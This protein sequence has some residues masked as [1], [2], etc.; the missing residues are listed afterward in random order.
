MVIG[1]VNLFR[2]DERELTDADAVAAQALADVATIAILQHRVAQEAQVVN[3]QLGYALN[4]RAVIEQA[5][6][7]LAERAGLDMEQAF[8]V[9]RDRARSHKL[10]LA[11]VAQDVIGTTLVAGALR[12]LAPRRRS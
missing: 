5:K 3:E 6:G 8:S 2:T 9:L 7:V 10:R 11:D 4:T 12:P 1:A